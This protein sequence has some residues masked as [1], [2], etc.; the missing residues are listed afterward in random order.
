M[1]HSSDRF[2]KQFGIFARTFVRPGLKH[3]LDA[4][5]EQGIRLVQLNLSSAGLPTLPERFEPGQVAAIA[6]IIRDS[7]LEV[8]ALSGTFNVIDPDVAKRRALVKRLD[9]LAANCRE[10]GTNLITLCTGTRDPADMWKR[11]PENDSEAAWSDLVESMTE[12]AQIAERHGITIAFEPELANVIDSAAKARRLL[13]EIGSDRLKIVFDAANLIRPEELGQMTSIIDDALEILGPD[14]A[15]FHCKEISGTGE[16]GETA[17]GKGVLDFNRLFRFAIKSKLDVPIIMHGLAEKDVALA[18][19]HLANEFAFAE[20]TQF[21]DCDG[22]RFRYFDI[23]SGIPIVFQHG[24]GGDCKKIFDLIHD[25]PAIRLISF[26]ARYHG[27]TRPLG[28][29]DKIAFR[30]FADDLLALLDHLKIDRAVIGGIS[31]GAGMALEFVSRYPNR[32]IGLALAR[33][34][35]F[36]KAFP[37]HLHVYGEVVNLIKQYGV[38]NGLDHFHKSPTY[39]TLLAVSSDAAAAVNG[40]FSDP[41][42]LETLEKYDRIPRDCPPS[43]PS[44]LNAIRVPTLILSCHQDPIH[45]FEIGQ[46]LLSAIPNS[47]FQELT[48]KC[49][50]A[51]AYQDDLNRNLTQF[52]HQ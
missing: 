2:S 49:V 30:Q 46:A 22:I 35:F 5:R 39:K 11:H 3:T 1:T 10:M 14:I 6:R 27:M 15:M 52:V 37:E 28:P 13:D 51:L 24:L 43:E 36:D 42:T 12:A 23:G 48:P 41:I 4:V 34:A 44:V 21:F 20:S 38:Q 16:V 31:M 45:P 32:V 50:D 17:P 29:P 25:D 18:S 47:Q 26:D 19:R 8:A 7:G 33:P 40:I 9:L